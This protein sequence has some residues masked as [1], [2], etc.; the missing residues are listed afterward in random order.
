MA[1]QLQ[2]NIAECP[3]GYVWVN[4]STY[5]NLGCQHDVAYSSEII[6]ISG[7]MCINAVINNH[8]INRKVPGLCDF[9]CPL[10]P[11]ELVLIIVL[12]CNRM[13]IIPYLPSCP[14]LDEMA[15][16]MSELATALGITTSINAIADQCS[17]GK[18]AINEDKVTSL[19]LRVRDPSPVEWGR[20]LR[21]SESNRLYG[22]FM[23]CAIFDA[24]APKTDPL[25]LISEFPRLILKWWSCTMR[26]EIHRGILERVWTISRQQTVAGLRCDDDIKPE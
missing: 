8:G 23:D 13:R 14:F 24:Y 11:R 2:Q 3:F 15:S 10:S 22:L 16:V 17:E 4:L 18:C 6:H 1:S 5:Y 9:Q 26:W 20:F 12:F 19:A 25:G 7:I 21:Y